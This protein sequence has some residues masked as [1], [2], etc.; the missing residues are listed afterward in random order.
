[1]AFIEAILNGFVYCLNQPFICLRLKITKMKPNLSFW[2]KSSLLSLILTAFLPSDAVWA[3]IS[4]NN[5][6]NNELYGASAHW[7]ALDSFI[8]AV[9]E[10]ATRFEL[11]Y[12]FNAEIEIKGN[13]IIGGESI[14]LIP[15]ANLSA[16]KRDKFRHIADWPTF[17]IDITGDDAKLIL[18]AQLIAVAFDQNDNL[19]MTTHVQTP[20]VIDDLFYY[21]GLLG[22]IYDGN[23]IS[24]KLWAPTA[25]YIVLKLYG[26]DKELVQFVEPNNDMPLSGVWQFDG[27]QSWDKLYYRFE[28]TVYHHANNQ[29]NQYEVTDPYSV[30]HSTDSRFSQF[31]D[32]K[33]DETLKPIGWDDIRKELPRPVDI[34]LY[35][36][37]I[38]DFSYT[39]FTVPDY[40]RGTY[41][42]FT[43]N[44]KNEN[45]LS[46][47]M[48]HLS[49]L[50]EAGLTHLH[51]LPLNDITT[52][53]EDRNQR[54]ELDDPFNRICELIQHERFL[55][56]CETYGSQTIREVF[57]SLAAK[58]PTTLEIQAPYNRIGHH[59][60]TNRSDGL[61]SYDGFN[62][63][64]DPY[65]FNSVEGSYATNP[66][67]VQRILELR[68][69]V[70]A[71]QEIGLL[72]V[73][74]VVYNHTSSA[75]VSDRSILDRVVPG[76]YMR[77]DPTSGNVETSTCCQNTAAEFAMMEKLMIDSILLWAEMYKIDSFR[78]DLMGHHPRYVMENIQ[79]ALAE[80]TLDEHGV[81]GANV[82][83][84]GEGWNFGEVADDRIFDQATQFNMAGTGIGN[85]NDRQRDAI[86]GGMFSDWGRNQGFTSGQFLFPNEDASDTSDE[87]RAR[88]LDYA[89]RIRVGMVGNLKTYPYINRNGD[90]VLGGHEGIGYTLMPHESVNYID[91]HDNETLWDNTQPKLPMNMSTEDR[92]RVHMLSNAMLNYGQGVPFYQLGT[93]ILRSK[94]LDR[95]SYDSGDWFNQVDYTLETHNWG[96]GLPPRWDNERRWEDMKPH[97]ENPNIHVRR[98]HMLLAH[99]IFMDQ[100][101]IRYSSPLF[102]LEKAEDVHKR[103]LFHNTGP[104]QI[105]GLIAMS[106]SDGRCAGYDLDPNLDGIMVLFNAD[107]KPVTFSWDLTGFEIH[108]IQKN[109]AD[110][111]LHGILID[112]NGVEIPPISA[113]VLVRPQQGEQGSFQCNIN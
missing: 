35:E 80:L 87:Q 79:R 57:Q 101:R 110:A 1:M 28:I 55:E 18:K 73:V 75:G 50:A 98:E 48:A 22:P 6:K 104:D 37:H 82:Y 67:G 69:M 93:D 20:G 109:G 32:L 100:L 11:Y 45:H 4:S 54:I 12:S 59:E 33:N 58:D 47:G 13:Q 14:P 83:I 2:L 90:R 53:K 71:L 113:I 106:I 88:L 72:T 103:V 63:G 112:K 56:G 61:A 43:H 97:L 51:L 16:Y 86:R 46:D 85:F 62:W 81:D 9:P 107:I 76:Y 92:V 15:G 8:W 29:I 19:L 74:D 99:Q 68:E 94:S 77:R 5:V 60:A 31:A 7:V 21:D 65:H 27:D 102:R 40:H 25:Q 52:I 84:Y 41:M 26:D 30:S 108:S 44:G 38:R 111:V 49:R 70:K 66:E 64:Y 10:N 39:D 105:P 91:K 34:T 36:A 78:F 42:A 89:D 95:N 24:V 17:S 96:I 23:D 3:S